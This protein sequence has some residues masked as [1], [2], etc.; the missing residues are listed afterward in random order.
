MKTNNSKESHFDYNDFK[1]ARYFDGEILNKQIFE[2][3]QS[4][5]HEK[6]KLLNRML[7]GWGVVCGLKVKATNPP[8]SSIIVEPGLALD[9][10][11]NE[12]YVCE[13]QT[14][15]LSVK[16][17]MKKTQKS[18]CE[19]KDDTEPEDTVL[20][21]VIRYDEINSDP[22]PSYAPSADCGEKKCGYSRTRE[23][24]C[25]EVWDQPPQTP[26]FNT[27]N[28]TMTCSE[29][30]KC[31]ICC[32]DPHY[33]V[34]ATIKC[35]E[36]TYM[37]FSNLT[38]TSGDA[39]VEIRYQI[40]RKIHEVCSGSTYSFTITDT[41]RY[42]TKSS[43]SNP[44]WSTSQENLKDS[45]LTISLPDERRMNNN[46]YTV[47]YNVT[48]G[49]KGP[50]DLGSPVSLSFNRGDYKFG[51]DIKSP[52]YFGNAEPKRGSVIS[53]TLIRNLE[54]RQTIITYPLLSWLMSPLLYS[55]LNIN[56]SEQEQLL[57]GNLSSFF[58]RLM[59]EAIFPEYG[60]KTKARIPT[61]SEEKLIK[62]IVE[63]HLEEHLKSE[64]DKKTV[65]TTG[66]RYGVIKK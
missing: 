33:I 41:Y 49:A 16:P 37:F 4:Y 55:L 11:G 46:K 25:I 2:A 20:Y 61:E 31:P 28:I 14:V 34:L 23:G 15:D 19:D 53:D 24:F 62:E 43:L 35:G 63:K 12:I 8:S 57:S 13:E 40:Q 58:C 1:R 27:D 32:P 26:K 36:R 3:E 54:D 39:Q 47:T 56:G 30:F 10:Q 17:C 64:K 52:I 60:V 50:F 21:V 6:R 22:V 44:E 65:E 5:H 48:S 42:E 66:S 59:E 38:Q 7:H 9:C 29:P 51:F 45:K 18:I